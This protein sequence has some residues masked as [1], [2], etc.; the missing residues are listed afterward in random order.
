MRWFFASVVALAALMPARA[1]AQIVNVQPLIG[2]QQD[3]AKEGASLAF[4]GS[5]DMRRGNTNLLTISGSA[6][7]LY[8]TGRHLVFL[9][10][11]GDYGESNEKAFLSK[12]L[13]HARYRVDI[14]GPLAGEAYVQHDRD[15][16]RRLSLRALGGLG[17]RVRFQWWKLFSASFGA[18]YMLEH[19]VIGSG[20]RLDAGD[21]VLA[22]RLSTYVVLETIVGEQLSLAVT[23]YVQPRLDS[24]RDV[25]VLCE[26]SL[27]SKAT[28][29]LGLKLTLMSAYDA[30]PPLG[31]A[32]LDATLKGSLQANF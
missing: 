23:T 27:L 11:R 6:V 28:K 7:G 4:E 10:V 30:Q 32:P 2:A 14:V 5:A 31:V 16:F 12:D 13:E 1:S 15:G 22:H 3:K 17:P 29:H 18:S 9:M 24:F 20:N 26:T 8:R 21:D 19:E 25:R